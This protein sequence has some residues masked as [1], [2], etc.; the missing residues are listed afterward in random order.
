MSSHFIAQLTL[1]GGPNP[2]DELAKLLIQS[3]DPKNKHKAWFKSTLTRQQFKKAGS[4][5]CIIFY[6]KQDRTIDAVIA[7]ILDF[8]AAPREIEEFYK[9]HE[10]LKQF[11]TLGCKDNAPNR[12]LVRVQFKSLNDIPGKSCAGGLSAIETFAENPTRAFWEFDEGFKP[13]E[14]LREFIKN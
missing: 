10:N 7:R 6:K 9:G 1:D 2:A 12:D 14:W 8:E 5:I 4:S 13:L 11:W 3:K